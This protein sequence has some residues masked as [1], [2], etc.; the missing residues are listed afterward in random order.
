MIKKII[1]VIFCLVIVLSV[2]ACQEKEVPA[3]AALDGEN[4]DE[5][6]FKYY[7]TEKKN[8]Y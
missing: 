1:S 8:Q 5:A 7:F 4:I 6:Y 2:G 3:I